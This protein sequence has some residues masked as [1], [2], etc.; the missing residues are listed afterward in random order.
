MDLNFVE[1]F[2]RVVD[3]AKP[4]FAENSHASSLDDNLKDLGIDSLDTIM[5]SI[6]FG[7]IYGVEEEVMK[8]MQVQTLGDLKAFLEEH[9]VRKPNTLEE[10]LEIIK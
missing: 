2:N 10:A 1:L 4:A 6:Y 3:V 7:D 5:L 9:A 8:Q